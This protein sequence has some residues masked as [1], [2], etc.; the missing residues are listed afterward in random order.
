MKTKKDS[1]SA[2]GQDN[3]STETL[4]QEVM[5]RMTVLLDAQGLTAGPMHVGEIVRPVLP[6]VLKAIEDGATG[7]AWAAAAARV[8]TKVAPKEPVGAVGGAPA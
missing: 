8:A 7:K 3:V 4:K 6:K 5:A 2:K 1:Q